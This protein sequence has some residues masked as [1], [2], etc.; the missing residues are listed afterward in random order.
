MIKLGRF[1]VLVAIACV[2]L[3]AGRSLGAEEAIHTPSEKMKEAVGKFNKA[4]A[5]IGKSLQELTEA[6]KAKLKQAFGGES[7]P[8]DK[9]KQLDLDV[10]RKT[11]VAPPAPRSGLTETGR[12]PFR[13]PLMPKKLTTRVRENL[14]PLEQKDLS[15]LNLV[16]IVRGNK[17]PIAVIVDT[18]G[19]SYIVNVGTRIGLND[20]MVKSISNDEVI[21]EENCEDVYGAR[22]KCV[23]SMR[24]K[25]E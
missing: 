1:T 2:T 9:N 15:Q 20:G 5:T 21:M 19:L 4:P 25:T 7:K 24:L 3:T 16:G 8:N 10:P 22:K 6:A 13:P 11:P 12:D 23:R 17:E 14:S 18:A